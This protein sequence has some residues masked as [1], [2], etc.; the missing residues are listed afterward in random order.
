MWA[1]ACL[2]PLRHIAYRDTVTGGGYVF[3]F[4]HFQ[5]AAKATVVIY[6]E[7]SQIEIFL[8]FIKQNSKIKAFN[9]NSRNAVLTYS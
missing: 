9:N 7:R 1:A 3:L 8:R 5:L 6:K 2:V 4:K